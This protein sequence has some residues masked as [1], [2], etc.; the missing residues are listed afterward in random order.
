MARVISLVPSSMEVELRTRFAY[1]MY[2]T[3]CVHVCSSP[4]K[5]IIIGSFRFRKTKGLGC[6]E[7]V[8]GFCDHEEVQ[9]EKHRC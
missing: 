6:T 3:E 8:T 9:K 7:A 1:G 5:I 2:N 4:W